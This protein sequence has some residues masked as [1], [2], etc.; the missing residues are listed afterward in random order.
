MN[1]D[2][3]HMDGDDS[4]RDFVLK[5]FGLWETKGTFYWQI[6]WEVQ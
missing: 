3:G 5:I 2:I 4:N 1:S 6:D